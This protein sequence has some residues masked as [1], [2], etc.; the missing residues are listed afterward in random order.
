MIYASLWHG[1]RVPAQ[2]TNGFSPKKQP[3]AA[4]N[5]YL[6]VRICLLDVLPTCW[7]YCDPT[8]V[9]PV[10]GT[11]PNASRHDTHA[12]GWP[13]HEPDPTKHGCPYRRAPRLDSILLS[14]E[15]Q[16]WYPVQRW[17]PP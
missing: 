7:N 10:K 11:S 3:A 16:D 1:A 13:G 9:R 15:L 2:S 17:V 14:G 5:G 8:A 4:R 6:I 12:G